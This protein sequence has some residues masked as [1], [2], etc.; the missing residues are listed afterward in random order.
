MAPGELWCGDT[1]EEGKGYEVSSLAEKEEEEVAGLSEDW[2]YVP[3][4][5]MYSP[6]IEDRAL[7]GGATS[8]RKWGSEE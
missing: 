6:E 1:E 4:D 7:E 5:D 2:G 3:P 8:N